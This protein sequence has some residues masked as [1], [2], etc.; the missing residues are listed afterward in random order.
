MP[1]IIENLPQRLLEEA[2]RQIQQSGYEAMTIRSV[3][4][5]CGVGVGTVYNYYASKEALVAAYL[6]EDWNISVGNIAS[7]SDSARDVEQVLWA[8]YE[9]LDQFIQRHMAVFGD[10]AAAA[11]FPGS[12]SRYH[13]LLRSQLAQPIRKFC[14]DDFVAEFVAEALLTWTVAGKDFDQLNHVLKRLF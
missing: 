3:A 9:N 7:A 2:G 14:K 6:L 10:S 8:V 4:K 13:G 12:F 11:S 1:K 5:Q